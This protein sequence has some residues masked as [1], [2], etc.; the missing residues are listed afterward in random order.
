M[1]RCSLRVLLA[2]LSLLPLSSAVL[3]QAGVSHFTFS[4]TA[5]DYPAA[6]PQSL[7]HLQGSLGQTTI[8]VE[9]PTG[10]GQ[11]LALPGYWETGV[12]YRYVGRVELED[13]RGNPTGRMLNLRFRNVDGEVNN[14][15][16]A[17]V[18]DVAG[19]FVADS[20][21]NPARVAGVI[22]KTSNSLSSLSSLTVPPNPL[23]YPAVDFT[24]LAHLLR[25]GDAVD[26]NT[27]DV[28]DLSAI[29]AAFDTCNGD[30][31]YSTAPDF[32]G[33][34]CVDVLDLDLLIRN[35]DQSGE[36]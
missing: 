29:I 3:A 32:N 23:Q 28:L 31:G 35:F 15:V 14:T 26:D 2:S 11:S 22:A 8:T 13:Y 9:R 1:L 5:V 10:S 7:V 30:T 6:P 25:A 17:P 34:G 12:K 27:V 36:E 33:D 24:G 18:L 19:N 4:T 21:M 16:A 20:W